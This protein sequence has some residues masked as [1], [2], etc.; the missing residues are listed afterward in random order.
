MV[1]RVQFNDL[2]C[3]NIELLLQ[4]ETQNLATLSGE[5][6]DSRSWDIALNILLIPGIGAMTGDNEDQIAQSKGRIIALQEEYADR[7]G[8]DD[9]E[10]EE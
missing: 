1:S 7:C 3:K 6:I 10:K 5:Q 9:E 4:S 2:S 8:V